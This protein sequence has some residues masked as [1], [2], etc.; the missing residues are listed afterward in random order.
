M[1]AQNNALDFTW[2]KDYDGLYNALDTQR[3]QGNFI[4][5]P[6]RIAMAMLKLSLDDKELTI[7][8]VVTYVREQLP[9]RGGWTEGGSKAFDQANYERLV[10]PVLLA[11]KEPYPGEALIYVK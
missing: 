11:M 5:P 1:S 4:G 3:R 9:P 7:S 10:W 2:R 8:S 6:S